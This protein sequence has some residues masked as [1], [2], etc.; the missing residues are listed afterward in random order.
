MIIFRKSE[1]GIQM[2]LTEMA[3][4]NS[5]WR[6]MDYYKQNKV[7]SWHVSGEGMYDGTVE[8][9]EGRIYN[10]HVDKFHPKRSTCD[11][12]FAE[13]RKVVCKH[14][15]A[16]YFTAEPDAADALLRQAE[17][18]EQDEEERERQHKAQLLKEIKS[19]T[20]LELQARLY[21]ALLELEEIRKNFW[22]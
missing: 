11:C 5:I 1:R 10:V 2:G 16:V 22:H 20:K 6:G 3:S 14:M 4:G 12:A 7:L 13:G 18:W 9:S 15:I 19:L 8:G 17:E 21:D